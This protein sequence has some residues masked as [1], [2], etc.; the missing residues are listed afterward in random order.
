MLQRTTVHH[1]FPRVLRHLKGV[2]VTWVFMVH[3]QHIIPKFRTPHNLIFSRHS[4][5]HP[6][7]SRC[8]PSPHYHTAQHSTAQ[9]ST[10]QHSTAQHSTAQHS[11]AHHITSHHITPCHMTLHDT[12]RHDTTGHDMTRH[13]TT[14]HD[15][16]WHD[17]TWH[18]MARDDM[19]PHHVTSPRKRLDKGPE[20][21]KNTKQMTSFHIAWEHITSPPPTPHWHTT[22]HHQDTTTKRNGGG[23]V[24]TKNLVR[25]EH[26]HTLCWRL[27]ERFST[28]VFV[29]T[30][31]F[32]ED[33]TLTRWVVTI[34]DVG[35]K[36]CW[37]LP[38]RKD[39]CVFFRHSHHQCCNV[40]KNRKPYS[41][42]VE[43][44]GVETPSLN[45]PCELRSGSNKNAGEDAHHYRP[46]GAEY[47]KSSQDKILLQ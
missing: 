2:V 43:Q 31:K 33:P 45:T 38:H 32:I 25:A 19:S 27:V 22:S 4:T 42:C 8:I 6:I 13:D 17:M 7:R 15:M 35:K 47:F 37:T 23:L 9:H 39:S 30:Q 11:T 20:E 40:A 36:K 12:T 18:D 16:T 24:H 34:L 28:Q 5:S 10:T 29:C 41:E 46:L 3:S 21:P 14:R 1:P 44:F 26:F